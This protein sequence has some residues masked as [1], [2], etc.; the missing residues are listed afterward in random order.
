M[1]VKFTPELLEK[2]EIEYILDYYGRRRTAALHLKGYGYS[3]KTQSVISFK[4]NP[5][6]VSFARRKSYRLG[7]ETIE[8][9][10][11]ADVAKIVAG[12][13]V[14]AAIQEIH[15]NK[16]LSDK[17]GSFKISQPFAVI[18]RVK[19]VSQCF[20]GGTDFSEVLAAFDKRK[21]PFDDISEI[22]VVLTESGKSLKFA[23]KKVVV[24][25]ELV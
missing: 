22:V 12:G 14:D 8:H 19:N 18:N 11:I 9:Y 4:R 25:Y 16:E 15:S 23:E 17:I 24:E 20:T 3:T 5:N 2:F 10:R 1:I 21:L 6:G 7:G 13:M